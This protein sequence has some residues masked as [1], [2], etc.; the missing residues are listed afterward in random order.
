MASTWVEPIVVSRAYVY[1]YV[2]EF[3]EEGPPSAPTVKE[4]NV[5]ET[6]TITVT[7]PTTTMKA[8]R[9]LDKTRIYR[10]I[11]S[12]TGLAT[13]FF[14]GEIDIDATTFTDEY[15]DEEIA[16]NNQLKSTGWSAPLNAFDGFVAMPNGMMAAWKDN[17]VWFSEPYRPHAWPSEYQVSV[18]HPIVGLGVIGQ[19]IIV[20]TTGHPWAI[21]GVRPNVMS[22]SKINAYEPC[23]SRRSIMATTEGVFYAS[24]NGLIAA[25][26]GGIKNMTAD[27]I[28][29][30]QWN[31]YVDTSKIHSARF[32]TAYIAYEA[33]T[34]S[35]SKG[36]LIDFNQTR[37]A[38]NTLTASTGTT[39]VNT[40]TWS[41]TPFIIRGGAIYYIPNQD[42]KNILPYLWSSKVMQT[43]KVDNFQA[44]KVFFTVTE[45]APTLNPV[46]ATD[47]NMTLQ[48]TMYGIVRVYANG[49]LVLAR[50]LR[51]SGELWRLPSGYKSEFWQ[52]QV[53]ARIIV[54]SIEMATSSK[55]LSGV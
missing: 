20:C 30:A 31:S 55:E 48:S 36:F 42:N 29:P 23:V 51:S 12:I 3:G 10:T 4:G 33:P 8:D 21:S 38:Y 34:T 5:G 35:T 15:D 46:R 37:I 54:N 28:T 19:T 13:Y 9:L 47:L 52:V 16:S 26:P 2:T 11:T 45:G 40:D 44:I 39:A 17:E 24:P 18:D 50:E 6:W 27:M 43:P 14:V 22:L 1:T 53:E 32:N 7:P 25:A 49:Q 41:S